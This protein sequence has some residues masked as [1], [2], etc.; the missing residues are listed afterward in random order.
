MEC[1]QILL[2]RT[3]AGFFYVQDLSRNLQLI[4]QYA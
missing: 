2:D 3:L 4:A 1:V